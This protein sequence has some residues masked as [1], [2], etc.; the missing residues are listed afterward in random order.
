[1]SQ[2]QTVPQLTKTELAAANFL[3]AYLEGNNRAHMTADGFIDSIVSVVETA[4]TVVASAAS[5]VAARAATMA[6][7]VSDGITADAAPVLEAAA[8]AGAFTAPRDAAALTR[9]I[10]AIGDTD[11]QSQLTLKTLIDLRNQYT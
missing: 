11:L 5:V 8:A 7:V 2:K 3:I 10:A 4:A 6:N 9:L 1:M